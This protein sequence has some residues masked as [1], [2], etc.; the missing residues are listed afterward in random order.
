MDDS[1]KAELG[2]HPPEAV[3]QVRQVGKHSPGPPQCQ[4]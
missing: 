4:P 3:L 2:D 1:V